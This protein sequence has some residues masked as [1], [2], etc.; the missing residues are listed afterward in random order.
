MDADAESP[1]GKVLG[2]RG[3]VGSR[4]EPS[5]PASHPAVRMQSIEKS[6]IVSAEPQSWTIVLLVGDLLDTADRTLLFAGRDDDLIEKIAND[7]MTV[8]GDPDCLP[9]P[10]EGAC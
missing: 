5:R 6:R 7:L 3:G 4:P 8:R 2:R 10:S 9:F 1:E